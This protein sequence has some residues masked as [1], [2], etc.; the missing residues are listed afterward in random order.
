MITTIGLLTGVV[1]IVI[2]YPFDTIKTNLQTN[3]NKKLLEITKYI[4]QKNGIKGFYNGYKYPLFTSIFCNSIFF[5]GYDYLKKE[6][7]INSYINGAIIG[8]FGGFI[9]QPFEVFKC[10]NQINQKLKIKNFY[11]GI[12]WTCIRE[13]IASSI[14]FGSFEDLKKI[15]DNTFINGGLAGILCHLISYPI[16]TIKTLKNL[17]IQIKPK[18]YFKGLEITLIR[19]FLV[20]SLVLSIY[21]KLEKK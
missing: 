18:Y 11:K 4:Y 8:F 6:Y 14:Y 9:I 20:N 13:C 2:G 3:Q 17:D 1:Q 21:D 19:S 12:F 15:N 16:D 5:G 7:N 10:Q